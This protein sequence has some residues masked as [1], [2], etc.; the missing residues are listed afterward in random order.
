MKHAAHGFTL[1]ELMTAILVLGILF[2]VALPSF[3]EMTRNNRVAGTQNDL[4]TALTLARS[5]ALHRSQNVSVCATTDGASC[6]GG[7]DWTAGWIAFTDAGTAGSIDAGDE[8]LQTWSVQASE[9]RLTGSAAFVRYALTGMLAT[10]ATHTVDVFHT[11]C[12]GAKVSRVSI[13]AVGSLN[14]TKRNCP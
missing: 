3:R 12:V 4:L 13:S 11:G 14:T 2:A 8:P 9:T 10:P 7:T 6:S 1:I 5:E